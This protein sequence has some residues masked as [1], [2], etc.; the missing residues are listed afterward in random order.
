[1]K[2]GTNVK[3]VLSS[4]VLALVALALLT[5]PILAKPADDTEWQYDKAIQRLEPFLSLTETGNIVLDPPAGVIKHIAP[6]VYLSILAGL[7]QT[8]LM[9][10]QG[11]LTVGEDFSLAVAAESGYTTQAIIVDGGGGYTGV[12]KVVWYWW[13]FYLYLS[14]YNCVR[15]EAGLAITAAICTLIP[16]P[17]ASKLI[18]IIT[19][20]LVGSIM[21]ADMYGRGVKI[22]FHYWI[23]WPNII[24]TGIWSQ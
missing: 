10:D 12:T 16:E 9:I 17:L 11:Y 7:E 8:N 14:H 2:G 15:V 13:G 19:A 3:K 1:M 24:C 4:I 18:A 23:T 21:V 6:E 5:Q 22:R 20:S